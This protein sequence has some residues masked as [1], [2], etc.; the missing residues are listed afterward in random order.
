MAPGLPEAP[1][2]V[3]NSTAEAR[4]AE[5]ISERCLALMLREFLRAPIPVLCADAFIAYLA[6]GHVG[7]FWPSV[8]FA[9]AA[10]LQLYRY[11]LARSLERRTSLDATRT[12]GSLTKVFA[13]IGLLK[14]ALLPTVFTTASDNDA[15][16]FLATMVITGLAA[17]GVASVAGIVKALLAWGGPLFAVLIGGWLWRGGVS[18]NAIALLLALLFAVLLAY[19]RDQRQMIEELVRLVDDKES[20]SKSLQIE[21]DRAEVASAGK[22]RFFA[23]ASHDLR[24][25]LHALSINATTLGLLANRSDD[26]RLKDV[27]RG[28][29]SALSQSQSL[30]DGLLDIS[31]LD[32]RAVE[33][34]LE[35]MDIGALLKGIHDEYQALA[36]QKGLSLELTVEPESVW[37]LSDIDQLNRVVGNLVSNAVKFTSSGIVTLEARLNGSQ[38]VLRVSDTGPGIPVDEQVKV[39]EEFYQSGNPSRDRAQGMGLGL[40]IVK[41]TCELLAI[42]LELN[43]EPGAGTSFLLRFASAPAR[44]PGP[45]AQTPPTE[46]VTGQRCGSS[47][48]VLDDEQQVVDSVAG[49]L[50]ALGWSVR[51]G[52]TGA[53]GIAALDAGFMPDVL[54][55]DYRL[56][57]ETGLDV[58]A[59]L[60]RRLP[61]LPAVIITGDTAPDR[62]RELTLQA[63]AVLHKP[64]NGRELSRALENA[65]ATPAGT[66]EA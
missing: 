16:A 18:G 62:L 61:G 33:A 22:T 29:D 21:R 43:S 2:V 36:A 59:S 8:W 23:A 15:A 19:V 38:V 4:I 42:D 26:V 7:V 10:A 52:A 55:V 14:A 17:G 9:A 1:V 24:Q 34:N 66:T 53:D 54:V 28:I 35:P 39:F 30:L 3:P 63:N 57:N 60:R 48:L 41:R 45:V 6:S 40:A 25:P 31:R 12:I 58:I 50:S 32:A 13:A 51:C 20:L 47:A 65:M 64:V 56:R 27:S 44:V 5:L 49:Y 11:R 46:E 37:G